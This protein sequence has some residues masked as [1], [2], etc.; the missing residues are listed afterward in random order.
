MTAA[1]RIFAPKISLKAAEQFC[2]RFATAL[3]AGIDPLKLLDTEARMAS[4]RHK[5]RLPQF[6]NA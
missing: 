4:R 6:A 3:K 2:G 1:I 5:K